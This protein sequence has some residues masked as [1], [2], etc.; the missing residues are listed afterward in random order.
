MFS[1]NKE[2]LFLSDKE[3]FQKCGFLLG[4]FIFGCS[5]SIASTT[6]T[7]LINGYGMN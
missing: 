6:P 4:F 2:A 7:T 3:Y 1:N 5:V